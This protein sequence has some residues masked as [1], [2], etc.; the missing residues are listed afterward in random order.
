M[1]IILMLN[2]NYMISWNLSTISL[3]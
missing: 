1:D 3:F 2:L